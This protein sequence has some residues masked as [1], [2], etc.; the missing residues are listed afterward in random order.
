[1]STIVVMFCPAIFFSSLVGAEI[2]EPGSEVVKVFNSGGFTEGPIVDR[3]GNLFFSNSGRIM[4]LSNDGNVTEYA[5][6][7]GSVN[8]M[9]FDA[10]G[11]L[12]L[13]Q[14][15]GHCVSR[16][17]NNEQLKVLANACEGFPLG[18][19]NDIAIDQQ[20][21]IFFT[22]TS[23]KHGT[24]VN[25]TQSGVLRIDPDGKCVLLV[26]N[27]RTPNGI[28][29]SPDER[30]IFVADRGTQK[31]HRYTI[32]VSY[33]QLRPHETGRNLLCRGKH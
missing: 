32:P 14:N 30:F 25:R 12:Y 18:N 3:S 31:L 11:Q 17:I 8:G 9:M 20:G 29:I 16:L 27:L 10:Q 1:M 13:C 21:R 24:G 5:K 2:L 28:I 33:T 26:D 23:F 19:P 15:R 6:P 4:R 22:D 7:T